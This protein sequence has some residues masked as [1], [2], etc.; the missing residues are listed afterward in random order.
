MPCLGQCFCSLSSIFNK[1]DGKSRIQYRKLYGSPGTT[2]SGSG[3][4]NSNPS[5]II[6]SNYP[7]ALP[8]GREILNVDITCGGANLNDNEI[9]EIRR[10]LVEHHLLLFRCQKPLSPKEQT[11]FCEKLFG[12]TCRY[13]YP[14]NQYEKIW[15]DELDTIIPGH[16][17]IW[18]VVSSSY[19][20]ANQRVLSKCALMSACPVSPQPSNISPQ[21]PN[22]NTQMQQYS[23]Y[24]IPQQL[25]QQLPQQNMYNSPQKF[26]SPPSY[27]NQ[28]YGSSFQS[29]FTSNYQSY[30][31]SSQS[32]QPYQNQMPN[33]NQMQ[34]QTPYS[35]MK[36]DSAFSPMPMSPSSFVNNPPNVT[37]YNIDK[38]TFAAG[39]FFYWNCDGSY[40]HEVHPTPITVWNAAFCNKEE[41]ILFT[42]LQLAYERMEDK[43]KEKTGKV[44]S[45]VKGPTSTAIQPLVRKHPVTTKK[46]LYLHTGLLSGFLVSSDECNSGQTCELPPSDI[47]NTINLPETKIKTMGCSCCKQFNQCLINHLDNGP[48]FRHK[49]RQGDIII[50]DNM[51]VAFRGVYKPN[52]T[53]G[54]DAILYKTSVD[55]HDVFW[56]RDTSDIY[57]QQN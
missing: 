29:S 38:P 45:I 41:E 23:P 25:P 20:L 37:T 17:D 9:I 10:A 2:P 18:K 48:I 4:C 49:W 44:F 53:Q 8:F 19:S 21:P 14:V 34:Y 57:K 35:P 33:Q 1:Q 26:N 11:Q 51:S 54:Q 43:V 28:N 40:R 50:C 3:C 39:N 27:Q 56:L 13:P 42:D 31:P 24:Q 7:Q 46:S 5:S 52:L 36:S 47:N 15:N 16:P 6:S 30:S 55:T 32:V 22:S 12:E